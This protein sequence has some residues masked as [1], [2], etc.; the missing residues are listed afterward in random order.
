MNPRV[1]R[2]DREDGRFQ[3]TMGFTHYLMKT[4][5]TKLAF[6]PEMTRDQF[7]VWQVRVKEKLEALMCFPDFVPEQPEPVR[8]WSEP[9][10]EYRIEKWEAFP[11]PGSVVPFLV[12][13]PDEVDDANPGSAVMCMPGSASSKELLA[14]E[15]ELR[16]EQPENRHPIAN[17]MGLQYVKAGFVAVIAENPGIGELDEMPINGGN[18]NTGRDKLCGELLMLGRNYVGLSVFQKQHILNWMKRQ[19]WVDETRLALSGH[20]LGTEPGMCLAILDEDV[21]ALVFNDFL[22]D[23]RLRYTTAA[24]PDDTWRH[25]NPIWH[26]IPGLVDCFEFPDLLASLAPRHL[27]ICEGGAIAHLEQVQKAYDLVGAS[28]NYVYH[29]YPR[30]RDPADRKYDH[31]TFPEGLTLEAWFEY[32]NV[33]VVNHNFKGDVAVP[34]L[35]QVMGLDGG[36]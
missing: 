24:K 4:G 7:D 19:P 14:G 17:Q 11:E 23:N 1:Y 21:R 33:D 3:T 35:R 15:P 16:P 10:K 22:S 13:I 34:W 28:D 30:Y 26:I 18:P 8:L 32:V 27:I 29:F 31:A 9:R 2:T 36:T 20:S 6:D 25:N 12:L 5:S